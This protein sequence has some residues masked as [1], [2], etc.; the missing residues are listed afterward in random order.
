MVLWHVVVVQRYYTVKTVY[1][2][3][4]LTKD[5]GC[6][7]PVVVIEGLCYRILYLAIL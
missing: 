2:D 1:N 6:C 5:R 7:G 4:A 3:Q